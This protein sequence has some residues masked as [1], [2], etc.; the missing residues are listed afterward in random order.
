MKYMKSLFCIFV[1]SSVVLGFGIYQYQM[2][3]ALGLALMIPSICV[4]G[5]VFVIMAVS[6]LDSGPKFSDIDR[7]HRLDKSKI[8]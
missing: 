1:L 4:M 5:L 8:P 6:Y 2:D 3:T 7:L